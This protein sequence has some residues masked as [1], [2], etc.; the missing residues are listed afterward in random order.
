MN[1]I[2]AETE[3]ADCIDLLIYIPCH[4]DFELALMNARKIRMQTEKIE[5][6]PGEMHFRVKIVLSINGVSLTA[7]RL[8]N[9]EAE[10]DVLIYLEES[11]GG[12]SNISLGFVMALQI[13]PTYFWILSANE[14]LQPGAIVFLCNSIS[15]NSESDIIITNSRHRTRNFELSNVF[16]NLPPG[17]GLGFISGVIYNFEKMKKAFPAALKFSWT[18]WGQLAVLQVACNKYGALQVSEIPDIEIYEKPL[19]FLE[20]PT[21]ESLEFETVRKNYNHSFFGTPILIASLFSRD[22]KLRKQVTRNWIKSNWFRI[23]YFNKGIYSSKDNHPVHFDTLWIR[24]IST[25]FFFK[26][27]LTTS[28]LSG[29]GIIIPFEKMAKIKIFVMIKKKFIR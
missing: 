15:N 6:K 28:I 23:N 17:L 1:A 25:Q 21:S 14:V 26:A 2:N 11:I 9:I 3:T 5:F 22:R 7:Q 20:G 24:K 8:K 19:T 16:I 4:T 29:V 18:G 27:G 12:D 13:R 10:V